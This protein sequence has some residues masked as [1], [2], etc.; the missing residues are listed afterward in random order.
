M[1]CPVQES[2]PVSSD[3][4]V[5]PRMPG[6]ASSDPNGMG[7]G[8]NN[9]MA[10][11]PH[12]AAAHADRP[13]ARHPR[14]IE[15]WC[16]G[17]YLNLGCWRCLGHHYAIGWCAGLRLGLRCNGR[18]RGIGLG[19]CRLVSGLGLISIG[20]IRLISRD[21]YNPAFHAPSGQCVKAAN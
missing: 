4:N 11:G 6:P 20:R 15:A 14:V 13:V 21:I 1:F 12:P 16:Y 18:G 8:P 19:G 5:T 2:A 10:S 7:T 17:D 3:P 9:I